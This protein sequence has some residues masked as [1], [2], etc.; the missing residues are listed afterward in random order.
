MTTVTGSKSR[1]Y[2]VQSQLYGTSNLVHRLYYGGIY[3]AGT[4]ILEDGTIRNTSIDA[5]IERA[6]HRADSLGIEM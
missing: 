6:N 2:E 5:T 4:D 3:L 1:R